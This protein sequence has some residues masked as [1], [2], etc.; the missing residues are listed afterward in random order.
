[1]IAEGLCPL[2]RKLVQKIQNWEFIDLEELLPN[3]H[4]NLDVV[5][6]QQQ[7]RV[8]IIQSIENLIKKEASY[9]SLPT[10]G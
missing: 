2:S 5:L 10:M 7:D 9:N 3:P 8:L 4:S 1:M 6:A